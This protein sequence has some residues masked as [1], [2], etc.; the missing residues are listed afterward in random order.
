MRRFIL[1]LEEICRKQVYFL[2]CP[3]IIINLETLEEVEC[4]VKEV[5]HGKE[6]GYFLEGG[7]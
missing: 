4:L 6:H 2:P 3:L 1:S 5:N 7:G